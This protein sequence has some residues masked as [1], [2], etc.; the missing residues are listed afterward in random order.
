MS[1]RTGKAKEVLGRMT[2]DREVEGKGRAERE[3]ADPDDPTTEVDDA[4]VAKAEREVRHEHQE[5][6]PEAR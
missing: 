5:Y 2:G 6:R 4:T 3:A 1:E